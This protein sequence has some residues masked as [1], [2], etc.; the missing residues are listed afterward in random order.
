[1]SGTSAKQDMPMATDGRTAEKTVGMPVGEILSRIR[2]ENRW[3]LAEVSRRT[4]VSIS[5]LSKIENNHSTPAYSVLVRLAEG[6]NIDFSELMGVSPQTFASAARVITRKGTGTAY[7]NKMGAYEALAAGLAAK[8]MQPMVI[9]IPKRAGNG[10]T[11]R[12]AHKAEEFVYVLDGSVT[13]FM[14][15]YAPVVLDVGDSV[16][17]DSASEHGFSSSGDK[18][19]RILSICLERAG[20]I[21]RPGEDIA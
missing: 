2:V 6:L 7:V 21:A 1:M 3:T 5:S 8:S 14:D 16:Y 17:F 11:V 13:F 19:A 12:S 15:P 20:S 18:S 10:K 9:E 4:G